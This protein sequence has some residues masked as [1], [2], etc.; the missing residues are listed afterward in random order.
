[1]RASTRVGMSTTSIEYGCD[2]NPEQWS[3]DV[4][5]EDVRL[6]REVGVTL[7][8]INIFGWALLEP[9]SREFD[10]SSLDDIVELLHANGIRINLGTG[11]SSPPPWLTRMHP[12]ILPMATDGTRRWPGGRQ[13]WC[14]SS[15]I[16]RE[17]ALA[18]V[19]QVAIRYGD[20]PAVSL[21]H[22]SNELGC[23]NALC[24]CDVSAAAFRRWLE[25]RYGS[26]D[27]LNTAW[28]TAFWSQH[29]SDWADILPPRLTVSTTNPTQSLDFSRFSS[30]ELLGHYLAEAAV[31]RELSAIPVTTNFMITSHIRTQDYWDWA[32]QVDVVANDHYL[33]HRIEDPH[34]ELSFA[35][36]LTR[37][38]AGGAP[39]ILMEQ[40][41]GSVNWQPRNIAKAPGE[42]IRNSLAHLARGA[43][44]I[45]F[46]QWR[47]SVQG[48]EKFHSAMLPH[49]GEDSATWRE[50]GEL[51][52]ILGSLAE[53]AGSRVVADAAIV[54]SWE[55]WWAVDLDSRPSSDVRYLDEV[56][57]TYRQLWESGITVDFVA[58]G[59]D[60]SA[61]KIVVVPCLYLV[62]DDAALV[63]ERYVAS[64]GHLVVSFFSGIVDE[65][66]RIR[67]GGYPGAFRD[68]LGVSTEEFFP[69]ADGQ[70]VL[71]DDGSVAR[72]WTERMHL[73]GASAVASYATGT[74]AGVPAIA[75]NEHGAGVAWYVGTR[76][77]PEFLGALLSRAT[78]DAGVTAAGT[79]LPGMDTTGERTSGLE[80]VLRRSDEH[81]YLFLINH[82]DGPVTHAARGFELTTGT[83]IEH[84]AEVPACGVRVVRLTPTEQIS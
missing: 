63:I 81:D 60:L 69:L 83:A 35:G 78:S 73:R 3:P 7:V 44:G 49:A 79:T 80:V 54:F 57:R 15:P 45:C 62:S 58:P 65:D 70:S 33:D 20:H 50:V 82:T 43:D 26:I 10:F 11:T 5:A 13:A 56:L 47:A 41:T 23:H 38:L 75:R 27:A 30:D 61:Y 67:L 6:M 84:S 39:W 12:E 46:F 34:Q 24:Y 2:Y 32:P 21:W 28:G 17:R 64:G 18:L 1:M 4:W 22:V 8:A 52:R 55:S 9:R 68:L 59:A 42:M 29:Y 19:T 16:F 51:G 72:V 36:D 25:R 66:D 71:L 76:L 48:S 31:L 40:S 53:V 37:G 14:P 74:L 77:E